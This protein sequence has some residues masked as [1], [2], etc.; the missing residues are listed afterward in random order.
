MTSD[1]VPAIV[2]NSNALSSVQP[3]QTQISRARSCPTAAFSAETVWPIIAA[4]FLTGIITPQVQFTNM[5]LV[6]PQSTRFIQS[7]YRTSQDIDFAKWWYIAEIQIRK[8]DYGLSLPR[9]KSHLTPF[10]IVSISIP[11]PKMRIAFQTIDA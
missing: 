6:V 1:P 9:R 2:C 4:S 5:F 10:Y 11:Q 7:A 3:L 8:H